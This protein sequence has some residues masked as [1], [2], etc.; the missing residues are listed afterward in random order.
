PRRII[1]TRSASSQRS[2]GTR[3]VR[4][5]PQDPSARAGSPPSPRPPGPRPP[6]PRT[7]PAC[8]PGDPARAAAAPAQRRARRAP[9]RPPARAGRAGRGG[10]GGRGLRGGAGGGGGGRWGPARHFLLEV[11]DHLF[12]VRA[13]RGA[14][15]APQ[16]GLV[17]GDRVG[18]MPQLAVALR[19]VEQERG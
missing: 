3:T 16:V 19:D 15:R 7:T 11:T 6:R 13:V 10:R 8:R 1:A 17:E 12:D 4:P 5:W 9:T 2:P 18:G 14:R